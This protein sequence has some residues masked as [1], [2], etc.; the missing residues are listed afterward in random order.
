MHTGKSLV[1]TTGLT[2]VT[3]WYPSARASDVDYARARISDKV[4]VI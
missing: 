1:L 4:R 2:L 3:V